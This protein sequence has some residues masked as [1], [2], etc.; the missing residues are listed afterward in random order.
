M[1]RLATRVQRLDGV[2]TSRRH[3]QSPREIKWRVHFIHA[4]GLSLDAVPNAT[5]DI[6][7]SARL[8]ATRTDPRF[9]V[10]APGG[11]FRVL[12]CDGHVSLQMGFGEGGADYHDDHLTT[13]TE[14]SVRETH[15]LEDLCKGRVS[16]PQTRD[17]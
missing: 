15:L 8:T 16:G 9:T 11:F 7:Y 12:K 1:K 13:S 5:Y 3:H 4:D 6:V 2:E 10:Q 17:Y 14:V